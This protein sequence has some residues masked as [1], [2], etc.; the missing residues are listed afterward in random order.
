M[1]F[2]FVPALCATLWIFPSVL[3]SFPSLQWSS[4]LLSASAIQV[5]QLPACFPVCMVLLQNHVVSLVVTTHGQDVPDQVTTNTMLFLPPGSN[6]A[7]VELFIMPTFVV[8]I[9]SVSADVNFASSLRT[10]RLLTE[11]GE[12]SL[13]L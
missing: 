9:A 10:T 5:A 7:R 6:L 12:Y 2:A 11:V 3:L 13:I 1:C 4:P 8:I